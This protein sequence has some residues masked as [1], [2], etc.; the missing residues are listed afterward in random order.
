MALIATLA[1]D[2]GQLIYSMVPSLTPTPDS[3]TISI[4][5]G[6]SDSDNTLGGNAPFVALYDDDGLFIGYYKPDRNKIWEG[7]T[8]SKQATDA[9]FSVP[10]L[11]VLETILCRQCF[12]SLS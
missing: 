3:T 2:V 12:Q 11:F 1:L 4:S 9:H 5:V 8:T 6:H 7:G 10:K